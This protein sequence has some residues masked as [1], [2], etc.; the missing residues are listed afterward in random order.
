MITDDGILH[1]FFWKLSDHFV[2]SS[3]LWFIYRFMLLNDFHAAVS[4]I[5]DIKAL[6]AHS[7][8][9]SVY[10]YYSIFFIALQI[11]LGGDTVDSISNNTGEVVFV[12]SFTRTALA[13]LF[14]TRN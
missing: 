8:L 5:R 3:G 13:S 4:N 1:A 12:P 2:L 7:P 11:T 14:S 10:V 6:H 9:I